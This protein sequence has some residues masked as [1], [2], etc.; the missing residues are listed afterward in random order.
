M[1]PSDYVKRATNPRHY[2][3]WVRRTYQEARQSALRLVSAGPNQLNPLLRR[4]RREETFPKRAW[5]VNPT[6]VF[7]N[8]WSVS[9]MP[10]LAHG[11]PRRKSRRETRPFCG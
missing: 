7:F 5:M 1:A 11:G 6:G 3:S 4:H 9:M 8:L 2:A 10:F